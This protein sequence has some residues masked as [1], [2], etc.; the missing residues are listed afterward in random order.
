MRSTLIIPFFLSLLIVLFLSAPYVIADEIQDQINEKKAAAQALQKQI[1]T[2]NQAI[3]QKQKDITTLKGQLNLID[4]RISRTQLE[5][6]S[7]NLNIDATTKELQLLALGIADKETDIEKRKR[8]IGSLMRSLQHNDNAD[9]LKGLVTGQSISDVIAHSQNIAEMQKN[10]VTGMKELETA[11]T[12]LQT[13]KKEQDVHKALLLK[14]K[15]T[16]GSKEFVLKGERTHK[17]ALVTETKNSEKKFQ[18]IV[19]D[20]KSQARATE[21]EIY[22]LEAV[23]RA[24]LAKAGKLSNLGD[25][26]VEW[27]VPSHLVTAHFHD[28][29]YPFRNVFEHPGTDIRASQGT[30]IHAAATGYVGRARDAGMGYSYVMLIHQNGF[31]TVYGHMSRIDVRDGQLIEAGDVI[32]LSG[33]TPGTRGAGPF[34]TGAHLHFEVR[35]DG[36][37]VNAEHYLP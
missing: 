22:S 20:L 37:P 18:A 17:D 24:K 4:T 5:I 21:A 9:Y 19:T 13:S 3:T 27:P 31:S 25:F 23:A 33:G 29:D 36:I 26:S 2:F 8:W 1:D 12:A 16:L 30:S 32:G 14:L 28:A 15:N 34:V 6:Q 7:T 35:K 10:I 11:R